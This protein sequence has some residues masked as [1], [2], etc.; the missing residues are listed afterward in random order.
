MTLVTRGGLGLGDVKLAILIGAALGSQAGYEAMVLG[1]IA[2]GI[3]ILG[4]FLS[5]L[6]GP[7]QAI[8]YAPFLALAAAAV[9]LIEGAA[10]APL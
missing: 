1:V 5:G 2:G 8:P 3:I 9:V 7:R 6:V 10:V 4:L